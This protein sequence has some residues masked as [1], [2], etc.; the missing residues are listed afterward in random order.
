MGS[1][2]IV[3]PGLTEDDKV[4][5]DYGYTQ[6]NSGSLSTGTHP[7]RC[8]LVG[9]KLSTG[10]RTAETGPWSV[11]SETDADAQFGAG[12]ELSRMCYAALKIDGAVI[13]G[14]PVTQA[15]GTAG[16]W[17]IHHSGTI[18]GS[19]Q[20]SLRLGKKTYVYTT[21]TDVQTTANNCA[22]AI[23]ADV[24]APWTAAVG[25]SPTYIV[26]VTTRQV[27]IRAGQYWGK[28]DSTLKA[29]GITV[30]LYGVLQVGTITKLNSAGVLTT[31]G[32]PAIATEAGISYKIEIDGAGA[33]GTATFKWSRD[34]GATWE[35]STVNTGTD[36][37]VALGTTGITA[38][39]PATGMVVTPAPDG[40][41]FSAEAATHNGLYQCAGG[42]GTD[43][44]TTCMSKLAGEEWQRICFAQND[45]VNEALYE[46]H[47]D[48]E[49]ATTIGHLE[50]VIIGHNGTSTAA[51]ALANTTCNAYRVQLIWCGYQAVSP[52]EWAAEFAAY[53]SVVEQTNPNPKYDDYVF[54]SMVP[55]ETDDIPSHTTLKAVLNN[56]T[57]PVTM[58]GSDPVVSRAIVTHCLTGTAPDYGTLDTGDAT[59]PDR[60]REDLCATS[61]R[62]RQA[63]PYAGPDPAPEIGPIPGLTETPKLWMAAIMM[64]LSDKV[65][66][67]WLDPDELAAHPPRVEWD[68]QTKRTMAAVIAPVKKHNHQYAIS[69]Q[70]L[71][72]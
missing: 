38:I 49:A 1:S 39:F 11:V 50:H 51:Q 66:L 21:I 36:A 31:T 22:N 45:S 7:Y 72:Y 59:T 55:L 68:T 52:V 8:L 56:G 17:K 34:A 41:T 12:S 25:A 57:T 62:R 29:S 37:G 15:T 19:G 6:H 24:K 20:V 28:L 27:G 16:S 60:V 71:A 33:R 44:V 10:S 42:T 5:G 58:K 53:R 23:N 18:V 30:N 46:T 64:Y 13:Y 2:L 54:R 26:T 65:R 43:D 70:Q 4:P 67:N 40:W 69:V 14:Y 35:A 61:A 48:G 9:N 3:V 32:T 47:V 63:L